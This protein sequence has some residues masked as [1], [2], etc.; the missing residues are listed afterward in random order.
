MYIVYMGSG[1]WGY[2]T[3]LACIAWIEST[4]S[5]LVVAVAWLGCEGSMNL[6][7]QIGQRFKG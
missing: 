7:G 4:S 1:V 3:L 5:W 2:R 6:L